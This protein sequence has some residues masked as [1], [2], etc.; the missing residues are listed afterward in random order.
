MADKTLPIR[1]T[2]VI[3]IDTN[4]LSGR[5]PSTCANNLIPALIQKI[6]ESIDGYRLKYIDVTISGIWDKENTDSKEKKTI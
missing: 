5:T 4:M 6:L 2:S 3:R 1:K